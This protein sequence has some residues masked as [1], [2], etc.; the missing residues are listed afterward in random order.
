[1]RLLISLLISAL[2]VSS[3]CSSRECNDKNEPKKDSTL[4]T[5]PL[6]GGQNVQVNRSNV[7]LELIDIYKSSSGFVILAKVNSVKED[8]SYPSLAVI[9]ET[10]LLQ[11]NYALDEMGIMIENEKNKN[12]NSLTELKTGNRFSAVIFF[13]LNKG[14]FI[15]N[16][17]K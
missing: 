5:P 7:S 16:I 8:D 6:G 1:M 15:D 14:W 3:C 13:E 12:L 17:N 9:G 4:S 11:P 2:L 10:Y